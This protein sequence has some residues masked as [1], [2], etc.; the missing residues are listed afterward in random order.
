M[1]EH[2]GSCCDVA[3]RHTAGGAT[4]EQY[5]GTEVSLQILHHHSATHAN[6]SAAITTQSEAWLPK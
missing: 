6:D 3:P 4:T 2:P 1:H 5:A